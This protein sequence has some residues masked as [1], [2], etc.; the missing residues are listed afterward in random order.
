M[1]VK[2]HGLAHDVGHLVVAAVIH[3]LHCVQDAA[4]HGLQ[5]VLDARHRTL[6]D[7]V[8]RIVEK[9]VLVHA[10]QMVHSRGIEAVGRL[11]VGVLV[12]GELVVSILDVLPFVGSFVGLVVGRLALSGRSRFGLVFRSVVGRVVEW[13]IIGLLL[14]VFYLVVVHIVV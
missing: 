8:R 1:G 10:R 5:T 9:P 12:L 14:V 2:L 7:D 11:I 6:Q 13:C 4:L 3:A